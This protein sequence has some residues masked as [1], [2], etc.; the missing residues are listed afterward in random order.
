MKS[1]IISLLFLILLISCTPASREEKV[2]QPIDES[3]ETITPQESSVEYD[4]SEAIWALAYDNEG[5]EF[6]IYQMRP[7]SSDTLTGKMLERINNKTWPRV[8]I[9]FTGT[10][11]DTAF[12]TIPSPSVLTQQM[13]SAGA[14]SFLISTTYNFTELKGIH[15]VVFDFEEGD[16]AVPGVYSR[17]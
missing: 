12:I 3:A 1:K 8:Q 17:R 4:P 6:E 14:E 15:Y 10:S 13:G 16:H 11:H 2:T 5:V 9:E 7:V